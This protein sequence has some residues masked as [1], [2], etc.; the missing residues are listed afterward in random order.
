MKIPF[1]KAHNYKTFGLKSNNG[2]TNFGNKSQPP[3]SQYI[4]YPQQNKEVIK[5]SAMEK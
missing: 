3:S 4:F 2:S 1:I 5:H